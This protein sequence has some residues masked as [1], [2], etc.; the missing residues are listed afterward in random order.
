MLAETDKQL[1]DLS[2]YGATHVIASVGVGSWAQAVTI[3]YK[4]KAPYVT[5]LLV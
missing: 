5:L 1:A 2:I 3:H 4:R